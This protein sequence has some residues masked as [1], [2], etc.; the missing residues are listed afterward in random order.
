MP[1]ECCQTTA[2]GLATQLIRAGRQFSD[3]EAML[4]LTQVD[5]FNATDPGAADQWVELR[6][7]N[8]KRY[9]G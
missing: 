6:L 4:A 1:R 5:F 2:Q 3:T 9:A 8:Y 7:E